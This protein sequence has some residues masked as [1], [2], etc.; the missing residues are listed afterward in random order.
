VD[1]LHAVASLSDRD[2]PIIR[3]VFSDVSMSI[4]LKVEAEQISYVIRDR[5]NACTLGRFLSAF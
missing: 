1:E 3:R 2:D 5:A 4:E